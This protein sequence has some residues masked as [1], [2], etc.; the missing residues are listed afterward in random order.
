MKLYD[1]GDFARHGITLRF[2]KSGLPEYP[3]LGNPF[4]ERLSILD[5]IMFNPPETLHK[6]LDDYTLI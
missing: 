2:L 5:A 3:Q 6:M 4:V 1:Y